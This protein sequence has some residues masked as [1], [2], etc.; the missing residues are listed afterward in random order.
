MCQ[1]RI[2][3]E[4]CLSAEVKMPGGGT[5]LFEKVTRNIEIGKDGQVTIKNL[6]TGERNVYPAGSDV[7]IRI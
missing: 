1:T 6:E 2:S 3:A 7:K 4:G 5:Y